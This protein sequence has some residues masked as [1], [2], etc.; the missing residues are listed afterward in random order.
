[1]PGDTSSQSGVSLGAR[2]HSKAA[3]TVGR[4][5][6]PAARL[7]SPP[8]RPSPPCD[9]QLEI[10]AHTRGRCATGVAAYI[11]RCQEIRAHCFGS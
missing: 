1:L 11:T 2:R 3:G 5:G 4:A 10:C 7:R 8:I 6:A 9:I